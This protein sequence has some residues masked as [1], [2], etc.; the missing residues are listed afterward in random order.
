MIHFANEELLLIERS[1][2]CQQRTPEF[3]STR[4]SVS[5]SGQK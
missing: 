5:K 2:H 4:N 1:L 3:Y